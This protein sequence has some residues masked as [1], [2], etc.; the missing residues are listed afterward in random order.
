MPSKDPEKLRAAAAHAREA[1]AKNKKDKAERM[2]HVRAGK[3]SKPPPEPSPPPP[4]P[5]PPPK[6]TTPKASVSSYTKKGEV[7][8]FVDKKWV[9]VERSRMKGTAEAKAKMAKVRAAKKK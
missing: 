7:P 8:C 5:P 4:P 2:A 9:G 6:K 1:R 3:S